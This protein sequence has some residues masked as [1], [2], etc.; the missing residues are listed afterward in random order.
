VPKER[1]DVLTP[2]SP[3]WSGFTEALVKALDKEPCATAQYPELAYLQATKV[4][5]ELGDV[6]IPGSIAFFKSHGGYCDCEILLNIDD[7]GANK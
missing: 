2:E 3:R 5:L 4:M 1:G 6:D 7:N